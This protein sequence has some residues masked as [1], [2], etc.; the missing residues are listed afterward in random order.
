MP[1]YQNVIDSNKF[2]TS[3]ESDIFSLPIVAIS[4]GIGRNKMCQ[5]PVIPLIIDKRKYYRKIDIIN[6]A[7]TEQVKG[8]NSLLLKLRAENSSIA[9]FE[10][11]RSKAYDRTPYYGVD[12]VDERGRDDL[13]IKRLLDELNRLHREFAYSVCPESAEKVSS[14]E[15]AVE[16]L[17]TLL[18]LRNKC[19]YRQKLDLNAFKSMWWYVS[20]N[21]EREQAHKK[22]FED[23]EQEFNSNI[24][25]DVDEEVFWKYI[26]QNRAN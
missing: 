22:Y 3:P 4:L 13:Q 6:W 17:N 16:T 25:D 23:N 8:K 19:N 1:T 14:R 15:L 20:D 5:I 11:A 12:G 21:E 24:Q 10:R 7:I 9:K 26:N 2:W 18:D